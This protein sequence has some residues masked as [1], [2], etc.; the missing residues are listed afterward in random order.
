MYITSLLKKNQIVV[1]LTLIITYK[2]I[3]ENLPYFF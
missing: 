2:D 1:I 3:E